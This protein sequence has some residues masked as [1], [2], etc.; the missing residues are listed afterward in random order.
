MKLNHHTHTFSTE[1]Q[2]DA[3]NHWHEATCK[4]TSEVSDKAAHTFELQITKNP[5]EIEFKTD[6]RKLFEYSL[7]TFNECGYK[8]VEL[9]LDLH[10]DAEV[11]NLEIVTTEY[12][13][14]FS[15]MGN[16]IYYVKVIK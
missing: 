7:I 15:S 12:E 13:D 10:Q 16:P 6:N 3:E 14:K 8:F 11:E 2:R 9:S 4:H 1:W 5:T